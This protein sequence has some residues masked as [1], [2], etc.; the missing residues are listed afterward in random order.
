MNTATLNFES[1]TLLII[2][3]CMAIEFKSNLSKPCIFPFQYGG[4]IFQGCTTANR[5]EPWC[6]TKVFENMTVN[7]N[8]RG[9]CDENCRT[10]IN[11]TSNSILNYFSIKY[12]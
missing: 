1:L 9:V 4:K 12:F 8:R 7:D 3:D 10:D 5:S 2:S 11:E 6:P